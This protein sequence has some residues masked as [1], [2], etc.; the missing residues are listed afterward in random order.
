MVCFVF[1]KKGNVS[2]IAFYLAMMTQTQCIAF[3]INKLYIPSGTIKVPIQNISLSKLV[4]DHVP[5]VKLF[6]NFLI[7]FKDSHHRC[8]QKIIKQ[9][10]QILSENE[11]KLLVDAFFGKTSK[12][13]ALVTN[14]PSLSQIDGK[15]ERR[16][17]PD[18]FWGG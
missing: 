18:A 9:Y 15:N 17:C 6:A 10:A 8:S 4:T 2:S 1:T 14:D 13:R 12:T 11:E 3:T 7:L 16:I 5:E